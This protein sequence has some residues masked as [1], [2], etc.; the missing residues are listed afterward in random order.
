MVSR[1]TR[2]IGF[3]PVL[4]LL[5]SVVVV[6]LF[7]PRL[8]GWKPMLLFRTGWKPIPRLVLGHVQRRFRLATVRRTTATLQGNSLDWL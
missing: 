2:G 8:K 7:S 3:Q 5:W 4:F 6:L 1:N